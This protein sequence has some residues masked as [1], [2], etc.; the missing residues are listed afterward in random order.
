MSA[1]AVTLNA[2]TNPPCGW[3]AR[4]LPFV[5]RRSSR[6]F[7]RRGVRLPYK[8]RGEPCAHF[9]TKASEYFVSLQWPYFAFRLGVFYFESLMTLPAR[10]RT[11]IAL[12]RLTAS[13]ALR[14]AAARLAPERATFIPPARLAT[15]RSVFVSPIHFAAEYALIVTPP[16]LAAERTSIVA[17]DRL[18]MTLTACA[19]FCSSFRYMPVLTWLASEVA[20]ESARERGL[21]CDNHA[22]TL[23]AANTMPLSRL[24]ITRTSATRVSARISRRIPVRLTISMTTAS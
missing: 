20:F 16:R 18:T 13:P 7:H 11:V 5:F 10:V 8:L 24:V 15:E 17:A 14:I 19:V 6:S 3:E 2:N 21:A 23:T 12:L 1:N 22:N 4:R 9:R